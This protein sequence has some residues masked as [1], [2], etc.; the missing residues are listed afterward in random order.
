MSQASNLEDGRAAEGVPGV[1]AMERIATRQTG[2]C[3]GSL[4][5]DPQMS[6]HDAHVLR[7]K[8]KGAIRA[9]VPQVDSVLAHM[10]PCEGRPSSDSAHGISKGSRC[11]PHCAA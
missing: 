5:A 11:D 7:G 1:L 8:T 2:W 4:E 3:T 9:V 10:E 6:L